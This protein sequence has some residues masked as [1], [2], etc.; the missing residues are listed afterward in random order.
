MVAGDGDK[1]RRLKTVD[2]TGSAGGKMVGVALG[3]VAVVVDRIETVVLPALATAPVNVTVTV[4]AALAYYPAAAVRQPAHIYV[5][6]HSHFHAHAEVPPHDPL[7]HQ[8][9]LKQTQT[10]DWAV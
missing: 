8:Q 4:N 5:L 3:A 9:Q 7:Q 2:V 1:L 6:A 10:G